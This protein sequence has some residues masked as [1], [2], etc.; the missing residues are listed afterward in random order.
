MCAGAAPCWQRC[1]RAGLWGAAG[2]WHRGHNGADTSYLRVGAG[3]SITSG[4]QI[5]GCG[6]HRAV[7]GRALIVP[8]S[9]PGSRPPQVPLPAAPPPHTGT[10]PAGRTGNG[11]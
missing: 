10:E 7:L 2:C 9:T 3:A 8:D 11:P 6:P 4:R 1:A 5:S